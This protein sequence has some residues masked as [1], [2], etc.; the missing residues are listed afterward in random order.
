MPNV[1]FG[2]AVLGR[3]VVECEV[4]LWMIPV[5]YAKA[6]DARLAVNNRAGRYGEALKSRA[7]LR[8]A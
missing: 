7:T 5:V 3:S 2:I 8:P 6:A 1:V 4:N